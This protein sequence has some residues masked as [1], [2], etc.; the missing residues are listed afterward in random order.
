MKLPQ[1]LY[2]Y[3]LESDL[4][5]LHDE[6]RKLTERQIDGDNISPELLGDGLEFGTFTASTPGKIIV[7][8]TNTTN[9]T[10]ISQKG[11]GFTPETFYGMEIIVDSSNSSYGRFCIV[12]KDYLTQQLIS[13]IPEDPASVASP[14]G[15]ISFPYGTGIIEGK[16]GDEI[17][18]NESSIDVDFRIESNGNT[19][20]FFVDA[21]NEWIT[22]FSSSSPTIQR[23]ANVAGIAGMK[24]TAYCSDN[25]ILA[26]FDSKLG[27][28]ETDGTFD[29]PDAYFLRGAAAQLNSVG[30]IAPNATNTYTCGTTSL[31][32]SEVVTRSIDTD[33]AQT[34]TVQ[35]N[36]VSHMTFDG[37]V[38]VPV[39][40]YH[41]AGN[42]R[43]PITR[44][45]MSGNITLT[46][47]S[48]KEQSLDPN[49]SDRNVTLPTAATGMEFWFYHV[50]GANTI[51]ILD[52]SAVEVV[53]IITGERTKVIY[54]GTA[55]LSFTGVA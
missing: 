20:A 27:F 16:A 36:N 40:L 41:T 7:S 35:R 9:S 19:H 50:G 52:A 33:G 46:T 55:W 18:F 22:I 47:S 31:A 54:D 45:V 11:D 43:T 48:N 13:L 30:S 4:R 15:T 25:S 3:D 42:Y 49:G 24:C 29:T 23:E 1:C 53:D 12:D 39:N 10:Y 32:W 34:L 14:G 26:G 28:G 21:G 44:T 5:R 38:N 37:S 8:I 17:V 51:N 2:G 6:V